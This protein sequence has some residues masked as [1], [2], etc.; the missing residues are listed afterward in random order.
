M[1][2]SMKEGKHTY[3]VDGE[4]LKVPL[5]HIPREDQER[6]AL[7]E[8]ITAEA[9]KLQML[10]KSSKQMMQAIIA[11]YLE[12]VAASYGEKWEGN[13]RIRNYS[14]TK[15][16]EISQAKLLTFDETLAVA[17]QKIDQC[18]ERWASGSRTEIIALVNQAFR[19]NQ[20]GQ[21]DVKELL[22]LPGLN[23]DDAEWR[24]AM[25]IIK[26]SVTVQSTKQYLNFRIAD[27]NGK[28][29]SIPLNFSA[30]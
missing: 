30:V 13:A 20:K 15:E 24:E 27:D 1:A 29:V 19:V 3:W 8:E 23:I 18:I 9:E 5:K 7:V 25:E 6:D 16:V 2:I 12:K 28:L 26:N 4:G 17:K 14:Q 21:V 22:K 11:K 10:I